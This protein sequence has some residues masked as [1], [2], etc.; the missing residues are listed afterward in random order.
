[1][2]TT[3]AN[4]KLRWVR[5]RAP[6]QTRRASWLKH[7]G[8]RYACVFEAGGKWLWTAG[9]EGS[10][11]SGCNKAAVA[12]EAEAKRQALAYVLEHMQ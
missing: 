1:M 9:P 7:E 3:A 6:G 2:S 10:V 12:T 4:I 5:E 11:P 8:V